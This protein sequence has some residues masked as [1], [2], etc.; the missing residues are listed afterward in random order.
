MSPPAAKTNSLDREVPTPVNDMAPII[1]PIPDSKDTILPII[2]P[3]LKNKFCQLNMIF[4]EMI[5]IT[6]NNKDAMKG[7]SLS[8]FK[9][10]SNQIKQISDNIYEYPLKIVFLNEGISS[11]LI[12]FKLFLPAYKIDLYHKC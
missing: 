3:V 8:S 6:N 10:N 9:A 4:F 2:S 5:V 7:A 1:T 11:I 12:G